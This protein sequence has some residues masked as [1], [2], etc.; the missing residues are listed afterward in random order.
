MRLTNYSNPFD[1]VL[2]VSN[3]KRLGV[4]PAPAGRAA[5]AGRSEGGQTS[6][7]APGS[8]ASRAA[9]RQHQL[10]PSWWFIDKMFAATCDDPRRRHRRNFIPTR[11]VARAAPCSSRT[12]NARRG[13]T[14]GDQAVVTTERTDGVRLERFENTYGRTAMHGCWT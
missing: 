3:A 13:W 5:A 8:R 11:G 6:T 1:A 2:A 12:A 4:A 14:S 7:A 9:R 10:D